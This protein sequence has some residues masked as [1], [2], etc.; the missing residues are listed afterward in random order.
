[1]NF[2]AWKTL[3]REL[4]ASERGARL[5]R[6]DCMNPA[7]A[8]AELRP[9]V[10]ERP[11]PSSTYEV[12]ALWRAR[13]ELLDAPGGVVL[14]TGI[15][16]LLSGLFQDF[17]RQGRRL[18]APEDVYPAYLTLAA[19]AGL[20]VTTFSS[21]PTPILPVDAPGPAAEVLLVPEPLVPLGRGLGG[22]E[23]QQ[24]SAWLDEDPRR[25]LVLD[26]AYTFDARFTPAAE[27]LLA[28]GQTVLLHSLAKGFLS[29]AV[30]GF[31]L[32]PP[33]AL[34][35]LDHEIDSD[36]LAIAAAVL[37]RAADL[38]ERLARVF[39]RRWSALREMSDIPAPATGYFAVLPFS[40]DELLAR[41]QLAVPG[42][43][44]GARDAR[45]C[46]VTCLLGTDR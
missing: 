7:K 15:R 23:A 43:V 36:A 21:V 45:W 1:V 10:P 13:F 26:C 31:A 40:F 44:F 35:G 3:S 22:H 6:L 29:P 16:P 33:P 38:P 41:G 4:L 18:H 39:G 32:G 34:A 30:A 19:A 9:A 46:A 24:L 42:S 11:R 37:D 25:L 20:P 5:L 27:A 28:R 17:A 14:S 12:E 8:L 2:E